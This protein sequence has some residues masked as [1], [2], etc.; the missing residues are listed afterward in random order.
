M[1]QVFLNSIVLL[2]Y[3]FTYVF[4]CTTILSISLS[5]FILQTSSVSITKNVYILNGVMNTS[6]YIHV[7]KKLYITYV[8][9]THIH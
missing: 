3:V 6:L 4:K 8:I 9:V 7:G 2:K 5:E 1:K